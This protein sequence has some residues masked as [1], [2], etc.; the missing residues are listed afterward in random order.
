[1]SD[2]GTAAPTPPPPSAGEAAR[3]FPARVPTGGARPKKPRGPLFGALVA[4]GIL[5]GLPL[6]L[7]VLFYLY[8]ALGFL[9]S[10]IQ[11]E[12]DERFAGATLQRVG[13]GVGS[14]RAEGLSIP[15]EGGGAPPAIRADKLEVAWDPWA[16]WSQNRI[17]S[18]SVEKPVLD[19]R[20]GED[21]AWNL[22]LP[23]SGERGKYRV[24][25]ITLRD[26]ELGVEWAPERRVTL[27]GVE[28]AYL[29]PDPPLP[30]T[31]TLKGAFSEYSS[32]EA[33]ALLGPEGRAAARVEGELHLP[34]D[35]ASALGPDA[36]VAG[37][38]QFQGD[39]RTDGPDAVT[40]CTWRADVEKLSLGLR[41]GLALV[42]DG[43]SLDVRLTIQP[44]DF[45][46]YRTATDLRLRVDR[47]G[48]LTAKQA[49]VRAKRLYF[50]EAAG[51]LDLAGLRALFVPLPGG[52]R[53]VVSGQAKLNAVN[54]VLPLEP[55]G[56]YSVAGQLVVK[57]AKVSYPGAGEL[58]PMDLGLP[59][60]LK[61]TFMRV[62][63][64]RVAF[65]SIGKVNLSLEGNPAASGPKGAAFQWAWMIKKL[66]IHSLECD[67]GEWFASDF[68]R[69]LMPRSGAAG[70]APPAVPPAR[71][72]GKIT[73][74]NV[75]AKVTDEDGARV[76]KLEGIR[77]EGLAL[78][79]WVLPVT[80]PPWRLFGDLAV[81]ARLKNFPGSEL[82]VD[83]KLKALGGAA[84]EAEAGLRV[85]VEE[86]GQL[87]VAEV[88]VPRFSVE[89]SEIARLAG[90]PPSVT[91]VRG[92][93]VLSEGRFTPADG[94][95]RGEIGLEEF[96][97]HV[98]VAS[99]TGLKCDADLT[100]GGG[101][102][103]LKGH[104]KNGA[105][106]GILLDLLGLKMC[107][108][109]PTDFA[110][111]AD[112]PDGKREGQV[113]L[114]L[115]WTGGALTL[116]GARTNVDGGVQRIAGRIESSLFG[117]L[118]GSYAADIDL[119]GG[120]IGPVELNLERARLDALARAVGGGVFPPG[121]SADG[122][123]KDVKLRFEAFPV[124]DIML[125]PMPFACAVDGVLEKAAFS[126]DG[127][128]T[129]A[130]NLTGAFRANL[131]RRRGQDGLTFSALLQLTDYEALIA[132]RFY[133][134]H[135]PA[136]RKAVI[137]LGFRMSPPVGGYANVALERFTVDLAGLL[138][139]SADGRI[140]GKAGQDL[141]TEGEGL[142]NLT[143]EIPDLAA[144][145]R[146][147]G[148]ANLRALSRVLSGL[149]LEGRAEW[150]GKFIWGPDR[151]ALGGDLT[152]EKVNLTLGDSPKLVA[153]DLRGV[154]P[155]GFYRGLWPADWPRERTGT[156]TLEA[157]SW[158]PFR[159]RLRPRPPLPRV[160]LGLIARP[161]DLAVAKHVLLEVPGGEVEV[162]GLRA[163]NLLTDEPK[164]VCSVN[165]KG[166]DLGQLA[167]SE[168]WRLKGLGKAVLT[169][170]MPAVQLI[171]TSGPLG[172]WELV[173]EGTLS[174][175]LYDGTLSV[176]GLH[177]RG[178][179]GPSPVWGLRSIKAERLSFRRLTRANPQFGSLKT[180][181]D[182]SVSDLEST[183]W[184]L[185]DVQRFALDLRQSSASSEDS[186]DGRLAL[187]LA[188]EMTRDMLEQ[189]GYTESQVVDRT[190]PFERLGLK[191]ALK[192]GYL[193]GPQS[194][195]S[196][197]LIVKGSGMYSP[198]IRGQ[199]S[200]KTSWP[201][202][203]RKV[204]AHKARLGK[205][206]PGKA[207]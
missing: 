115:Q 5:L 97:V 1:M 102:A 167:E 201:E 105:L 15:G 9:K 168:N 150:E 106:K 172:N 69:R 65:G 37:N 165:V 64:G 93:A 147:L 188:P 151:A 107:E 100:F 120:I 13:V 89:A 52:E 26:G 40:Q 203:V 108:L 48:T 146:S 123:A 145:G 72:G 190:F 70:G 53:L 116:T 20:R 118:R 161:N 8:V 112:L 148:L 68:G 135:P 156:V 130:E 78:D 122:A 113:A 90:L 80:P 2:A 56:P 187:V 6:L 51:E 139:V 126:H 131:I 38:L 117:G 157:L 35:L 182:L 175:P 19:L 41:D 92:R 204:E 140:Q 136:E 60:D 27:H 3:E 75:E 21:G 49:L 121:W 141:L 61:S 66:T 85:R 58:P 119:D 99:L 199:D 174:A 94:S 55:G 62:T 88:T 153:R 178:L 183:G 132:R 79:G 74:N 18:V 7:A 158:E 63:L 162:D 154:L 82:R 189:K 111:E 152:L 125:A 54:L 57:E 133:V 12:L 170:Q 134:P 159:L 31:L 25:Q 71:I 164:V 81:S 34:E 198:D 144:A 143:A 59:F 155:V 46:S 206:P 16:F 14:F 207:E 138:N 192:G 166:I 149:T 184:N 44:P 202:I 191:F 39:L 76:V 83:A 17:H 24:E 129:D 95:F 197:G 195:L 10:T 50:T 33:S 67:V 43:K 186:Y 110:V 86:N 179:F 173:T 200:L 169:G 177:A 84:V 42:L 4:A 160:T 87:A 128:R 104:M 45:E 23:Q 185:A 36:A 103:T 96:Q 180:V 142:L 163:M 11:G 181:A 171:R 137:Q 193:Y 114:S 47:L 205:L 124:R 127:T 176:G 32:L 196:G 98:F 28:L 30:K 109:P 22:N 73:A 194:G 101:K 29:Q 77:A 91:D